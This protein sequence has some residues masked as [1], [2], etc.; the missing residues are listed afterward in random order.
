MDGLVLLLGVFYMLKSYG[1]SHFLLV[2]LLE[3]EFQ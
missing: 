1:L 3:L 2:P